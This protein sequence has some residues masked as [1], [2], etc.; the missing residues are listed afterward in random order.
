MEMEKQAKAVLKTVR[1]APR[2]TRL[3]IDL[4][5][6]KD[7]AEAK[8]ILANQPQRAARVIEKVLDSCIANAVNNHEMNEEKLFVKACYVDEAVVLKRAKM[9]SRGHVG[10][11]D[12]K[13][14]HI[15]VIVSERA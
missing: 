4:I 8:A 10:R 5:R 11:N 14:S 15:T 7:V 13:T 1:I 3:V 12:H 6:G 2:K 9:D